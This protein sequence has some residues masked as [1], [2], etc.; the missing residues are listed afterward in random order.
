[1]PRTAERTRIIQNLEA[2]VIWKNFFEDS[3]NESNK[4][5]DDDVNFGFINEDTP[6][7]LLEFVYA[8]RYLEPRTSV[9]KSR[10]WIENIL[11]KYDDE[12]FRQMLR[13][14][15]HAFEFVLKSIESHSVFQ[16]NSSAKQFPV[17]RQLQIALFRFGRFGNAAS[18]KD[19]SRTFGVSEGTVVNATRRVIEAILGLEDTYLRW[20]TS[21]EMAKMMQRIY[22]ISGFP[23]CVGFLNGTTIVLAEK[24]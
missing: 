12:R 10:D 16:T 17:E 4:E 20:Y 7:E 2:L 8:Q 22:L 3:D 9:P 15:R 5:S 13:V 14:S 19:V 24:P 18:V 1:M 6:E 21:E 11:P 23:Y